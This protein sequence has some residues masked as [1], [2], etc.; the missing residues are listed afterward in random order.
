ML[1]F[2]LAAEPVNKHKENLMKYFIAPK[3][4]RIFMTS[5]KY[6]T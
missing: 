1:I 4:F 6:K 3:A 5:P 2:D